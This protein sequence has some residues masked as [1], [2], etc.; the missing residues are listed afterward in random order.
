M[1]RKLLKIGLYS[2]IAII[3]VILFGFVEKQ[4]HSAVVREA[5][6]NIIVD[7]D[8]QF[9]SEEEIL[10]NISEN[11]FR[12]VGMKRDEVSLI[13]IESLLLQN[14]AIEKAEVY[15]TNDGILKIKVNQRRPILRV[16]DMSGK[17]YYID[18]HGKTMP[19]IDSY[20][21]RLT[22][23]TGNIHAVNI[24]DNET[25]DNKMFLDLHKLASYIQNDSL[26]N[27]LVEQIYVNSSS[28]FE[29]ITKI[30]PEYI[31]IGNAENL[32]DKFDRLKLFYTDGLPNAG[33][34]KYSTINLK[35]N[36]QVICTKN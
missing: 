14:P 33:W 16:F 28:E 18:N 31:I 25:S 32:Q 15:V 20:T 12:T 30:G 8:N 36:N 7:T 9:V 17:S 5:E 3:V 21:A 13:E 11:G 26:I 19:L 6:V 29:L 23:A 34:N 4:R 24:K 35:I 10:N 2:G 22:V 27:A 1:K